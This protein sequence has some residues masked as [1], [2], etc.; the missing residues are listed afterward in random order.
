MKNFNDKQIEFIKENY[1]DRIDEIIHEE[2]DRVLLYYADIEKAVNRFS[3]IVDVLNGSYTMDDLIE[4]LY[5][6]YYNDNFE[7]IAALLYDELDEEEQ[8]EIDE[9]ED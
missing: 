3:N 6:E 1:P 9:L 4:D 5:A 7:D 2:M 8:Q